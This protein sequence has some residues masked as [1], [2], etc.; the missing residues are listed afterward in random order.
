MAYC[1]SGRRARALLSRTRAL[2]TDARGAAGDGARGRLC[3]HPGGRSP[4][5]AVATGCR[6]KVQR[7]GAARPGRT[8]W[9]RWSIP[10]APPAGQG[11]DAQPPQ[12]RHRPD[13]AHGRGAGD[14]RPPQR[15]LSFLPL[16]HMF[17]RSVSYYI[18]SPSAGRCR[19]SHARGIQELL[20]GSAE[21]APD[22][23]GERATHFER[24]YSKIEENLPA[25]SLGRRLFDRA[26]DIGWKRFRG[27]ASLGERLLWPLLDLLVGRSCARFGGACS[28]I[29]IGG[30]PMAA[31][32]QDLHRPGCAS[33]TATPDRDRAGLERASVERPRS[34]LGRPPAQGRGGAHRRRRRAAGARADR[35]AGLLEQPESH[36]RRSTPRAGSTAATWSSGATDCS[37]SAG[38]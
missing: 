21:P 7:R 6:P 4:A 20:R 32:L 18:R 17:E 35:D 38:G 31:A 26:V 12:H 13:R 19:W 9:P 16:S 14:S 34:H 10:P 2:A 33:S 29:L 24:V 37:T 28:A 22:P 11:R 3:P 8:I 27:E 15:F 30:A 36:A 23:D 25:S 5:V 1:L